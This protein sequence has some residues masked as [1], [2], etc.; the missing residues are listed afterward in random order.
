MGLHYVSKCLLVDE[1]DYSPNF[2]QEFPEF[3]W[4]TDD[5]SCRAADYAERHA[6]LGDASEVEILGCVSERFN[7]S[8]FENSDFDGN[9]GVTGQDWVTCLATGLTSLTRLDREIVEE[10]LAGE[11][12][13]A[14]SAPLKAQVQKMIEE[15]EY[16]YAKRL[17]SALEGLKSSGLPGFESMEELTCGGRDAAHD[18]RQGTYPPGSRMLVEIAFV[19][20]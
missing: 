15:G 16:G 11:T 7:T 17:L 9:W 12:D 3:F 2:A 10:I 6:G 18:M 8:E 19:W 4:L 20:G 13:A 14:R 5:L 1:R